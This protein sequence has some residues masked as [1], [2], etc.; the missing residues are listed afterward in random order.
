MSGPESA[1]PFAGR[2]RELIQE[3]G[4]SY[5]GLA[6]RTFY[7]KSY[8]HD[9]ATGRKTPTPEAARRIGDALGVGNHLAALTTD[10][11]VSLPRPLNGGDWARRDAD[12][13]AD[14]LTATTPDAGNAAHLAHQWLITE[15]PQVHE[16]RA[17]RRIG[18]ATVERIERRVHDLRRLDDH[19]GGSETY[20]LVS[21][22]L[23]ATAGLLRDAA[24]TETLGRRLLAAVADLCQLAGFVAA[25]AGRHTAARHHYLTGVRAAHA[26]ND[27]AS[28]A[29]NL[30]SLA[31]LEAN[32]GD[33][34]DAVTL[35]RSAYA[36]GHHAAD[37]IS[38]ALFLERVAWAH[39][40]TDDPGA[41]ERALGRVEDVYDPGHL[42]DA[43][44]WA[45]WLT[46]DEVEIMAGR[47]WTQLQRP[48]R[49]VPILESAT[50]RY[51]DDVPRETSLYLTWLA[52]ALT[53]ASEME[54][55]ADAATRALRLAVRARSRRALER[56]DAV[57]ELLAV[58]ADTAAVAAF[59]DEHAEASA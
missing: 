3:R 36:G 37:P 57:A 44:P 40:R 30:S 39:A 14:L 11:P 18:A 42:D 2:L 59:L 23:A 9:L 20:A 29:N 7:S 8:L 10:R 46:L 33:P 28:A 27:P 54:R 22:E 19:I 41:A 52:E 45:Y 31:Y 25:D 4:I 35:A 49:A 24:Y 13:L 17:G 53:Q 55:A 58:A 5:R 15:P 1:S 12:H 56:V 6:R 21:A 50:A 43:A 32:V 38:R 26:G 34:A 48:L 51:G 16:L 47:V